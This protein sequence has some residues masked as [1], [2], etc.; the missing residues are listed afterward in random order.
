[1]RRAVI[2][3]VGVVA[4]TGIGAVEHWENSV[5]AVCRIGPIS[6]FDAST[7]PVRIAGMVKDFD[8]G[9]FVP[10]RNARRHISRAA[11]FGIAATREALSGIIRNV[12]LSQCG[13]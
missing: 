11:G 5:E 6:S 9:A 4:P 8:I 10:D 1:M 13:F 2:T 7:F 3:G 12:A